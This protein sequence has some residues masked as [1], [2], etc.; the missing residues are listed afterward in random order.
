MSKKIVPS[1]AV[2]ISHEQMVSLRQQGKLNLGIEAS[3]ASSLI[4]AG[5]KPSG[6]ALAAHRTYVLLGYAA[7]VVGLYLA[8]TSAWWWGIFGGI[9]ML[10]IWRANMAGT[11]ENM[12]DAAME[13]ERFYERVLELNGWLYQIEEDALTDIPGAQLFVTSRQR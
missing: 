11:R 12:L 9:V 13:D 10:L 5:V 2:R 8:F 3:T 1:S 4:N 6:T 7:F